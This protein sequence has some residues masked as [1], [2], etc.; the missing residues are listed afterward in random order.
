MDKGVTSLQN[1]SFLERCRSLGIHVD[2]N[3]LYG[4]PGERPEDY[5]S[6]VELL[7]SLPIPGAARRRG[8]DRS[9]TRQRHV[10]RS[11][12][13]GFGTPRPAAAYRHVYPFAEA[14]LADIAYFFEHDYRLG[15]TLSLRVAQM[16]RAVQ[17]WRV[18]TGP[19]PLSHGSREESPSSPLPGLCPTSARR[20]S[21]SWSAGRA[22]MLANALRAS[23]SSAGAS[24]VLPRAI[25]QRALSR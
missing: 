14:D 1:V 9:G 24:F 18:R 13:R 2:W 25:R 5:T 15:V 17:A 10:A 12:Q 11:D 6:Q 21:T 4:V 20:L 19:G 16:I 23:F 7:G 8:A 22:P 3:L